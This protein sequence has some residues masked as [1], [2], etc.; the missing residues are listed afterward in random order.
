M[1][2]TVLLRRDRYKT[3]VTAA[4]CLYV[5]LSY[6]LY[7]SVDMDTANQDTE[8]SS[9]KASMQPTILLTLAGDKIKRGDA[10]NSIIQQVKNV[11]N[12]T[13]SANQLKQ[14]LINP[15]KHLARHLGRGNHG[16]PRD[17]SRTNEKEC[18]KMH[19]SETKLPVTALASWPG[20]GNTW[21]RHLI[22]QATGQ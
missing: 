19:F 7:K 3:C 1:A 22:Q 21:M 6:T 9:D 13:N 20:S 12:L 18:Q 17:S 14:V 5:L 8:R 11:F 4:I 16:P 15:Q 10:G 2:R